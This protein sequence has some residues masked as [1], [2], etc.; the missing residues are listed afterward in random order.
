MG[1]DRTP[2]H[3]G[4]V[5][6]AQLAVV[7]WRNGGG[8]TRE[9]VSSGG[10]GPLGFDW[11][12][13]IA[14]VSQPGPFSSFPGVDRIMTLVAG[15][16]MDL[17]IDGVEH[18]LEPLE[19]LS[20]DGASRTSCTRLAGTVRDLNVMTRR[21]RLSAS[22]A[23]RDLSE[24]RPIA[25]GG[26]QVL[27]LLTG[28]GV[29]VAAD[30]TRA[31]LHLLDAV[32]P[33]GEHVRLVEGSGQAAVVRLED[34]RLVR[35]HRSEPGAAK[36]T[37]TTVQ[38]TIDCAD[39]QAQAQFWAQALHYVGQPP[40]QGHQTWASWLASL[41]VPR[42]EWN[43]GASICDPDGTG[44]TLYFQR[45]PEPKTGKNRLHLDLDIAVRGDPLAARMADVEAEVVRLAAIGAT[46]I[47]RVSDH[48]HFHVAM[49]DPEGN[50]FDLR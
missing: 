14:D 20:F 21:D 37:A 17:V 6:F 23:I 30:G 50:E 33:A 2:D 40:P 41:G 8:L 45:V 11:R 47:A 46:L 4:V 7:P 12:I 26:S 5:R 3:L 27:V 42:S 35:A 25:V 22:V 19:P 34:H 32:C 44:P 38:L 13:S 18:A 10:S 31:E 29:V 48:G 16:R 39:P 15:E 49:S 28:A 36:T 43:D 1:A 9:V 24:T